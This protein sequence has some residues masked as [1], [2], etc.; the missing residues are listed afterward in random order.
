MPKRFS[1]AHIVSVLLA[2]GFKESGQT[3]SHCKFRKEGRI[4]IVPHPRK[5]I[6]VG[7]F[8]SILRQSGLHISD[9]EIKN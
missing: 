7:T 1:S 3:G 4:V 5:I 8:S 2:H 9:F 6:P